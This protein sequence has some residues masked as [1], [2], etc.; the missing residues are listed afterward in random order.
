MEELWK[1]KHASL[2]NKTNYLTSVSKAINEHIKAT[3]EE[4]VLSKIFSIYL[5]MHFVL[6]KYITKTLIKYKTERKCKK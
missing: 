3:R 2:H 6:S 5:K 4:I 1:G